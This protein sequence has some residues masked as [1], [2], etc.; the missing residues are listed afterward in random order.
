MGS[1]SMLWGADP[2]RGRSLVEGSCASQEC[3]DGASGPP[4]PHLGKG[5]HIRG[6]LGA[7]TE[8]VIPPKTA[9][10]TVS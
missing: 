4:A 6:T 10:G 8:A 2:S 9:E 5:T 3:G 1:P 7:G